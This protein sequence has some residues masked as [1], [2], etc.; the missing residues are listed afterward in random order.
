[1]LASEDS[2][3]LSTPELPE[4]RA[5]AALPL[6]S[7]G[8]VIGALT[9]QSR[10]PGIFDETLVAVLQSMAEQVATALANAR[11]FA[12]NQEALENT[13][14]MFGEISQQGW[15]NMLRNRP[16]WGFQ[17]SNGTIS[18]P[19]DEWQAELSQAAQSGKFVQAAE[20]GK[21]SLAAP[22]LVRNQPIGALGLRKKD[23]SVEWTDEELSVLRSVL[24]QLGQALESARLYDETQRKAERERIASQI[25]A[26]I[27]S[28]NDPQTILQ[29]AVMEL[30]RALQV[31][32]A[33]ILIQP[34]KQ[35]FYPSPVKDINLMS[36]PSG[37][38]G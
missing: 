17:L 29:T 3:R 32:Q 6:I 30:R 8:H 7:H 20:D 13:R 2:V 36:P 22:I 28:S 26:R 27:R 9:V 12:E 10:Q 19:Q 23:S 31:D 1:M 34:N 5:E 15:A 14:Q 35:E 24:D 11:L 18:S 33:Q 37:A 38:G 21:Y 25:T 4:T 16:G